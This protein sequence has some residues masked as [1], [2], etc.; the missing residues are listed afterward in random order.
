MTHSK[1][2][3]SLQNARFSLTFALTTLSLL[4][5]C[6]RSEGVPTTSADTELARARSAAVLSGP[7]SKR[8]YT[9]P[10]QAEL[11]KR[12]T[13]MQYDVTQREGTEPPFQNSFWNNHEAGLYVDIVSGEPLFSS[14]DKYESGTGWPS[15]TQPVDPARVIKHE[16]ATLGMSRTEVRSKDADS[17]LGHV[18]DDGPAP[19]GLRYCINSA[20]L[21]FVPVKDLEKEGYADYL[22]LFGHAAAPASA[23][24]SAVAPD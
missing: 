1:S 15:F 23:A 2:S 3:K 20:S 10:A 17:H 16:D 14:T 13:P 12:L 11:E 5:A 18:F 21:R 19:T 7:S 4:G 6:H 24:P 9:K 8:V 22:P